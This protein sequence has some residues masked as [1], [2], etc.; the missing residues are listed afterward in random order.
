MDCDDHGAWDHLCL[1]YS[2]KS[3]QADLPARWDMEAMFEVFHSAVPVCAF[4]LP[5]CGRDV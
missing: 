3:D 4:D 5:H 2:R 1:R